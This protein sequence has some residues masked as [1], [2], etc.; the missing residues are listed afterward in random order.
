[1]ILCNSEHSNF[2]VHSNTIIGSDM[3]IQSGNSVYPSTT[4]TALLE[5]GGG[6]IPQ[7]TKTNSVLCPL[8]WVLD[9][10]VL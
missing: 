2:A 6:E 8:L 10:L 3:S 5:K 1:M 9:L 7:T 4:G